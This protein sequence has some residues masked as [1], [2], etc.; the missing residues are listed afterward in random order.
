MNPE[1]GTDVE[2]SN[3]EAT[4]ENNEFGEETG[5]LTNN[6]ATAA[7]KNADD[8]TAKSDRSLS[9]SEREV[10][11]YDKMNG[12]AWHNK[13]DPPANFKEQLFNEIGPS[14]GVMEVMIEILAERISIAEGAEIEP[15]LIE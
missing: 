1:E 11:A 9:Q 6:V 8:A 2:L 14:M 15:D 13:F 3:T 5:S 7:A 12:A 10:Q 4:M